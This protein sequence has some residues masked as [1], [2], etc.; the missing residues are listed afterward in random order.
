LEKNIQPF[1]AG[2]LA[3][4]FAIGFLSLGKG[5]EDG[6]RFLHTLMIGSMPGFPRKICGH[7]EGAPRCRY[8]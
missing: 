4:K 7:S 3:I 8:S 2:K 1:L 6:H 5:T